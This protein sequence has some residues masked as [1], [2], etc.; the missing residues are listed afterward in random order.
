M[1]YLNYYL[2]K[3]YFQLKS[4]GVLSKGGRNFLGKICVKGRGRTQ[5]RIYN[6]IDFFRR[7]NLFGFILKLIYDCNRT[8]LIALVV[9]Q[10]G[11][12]SFI[13]AT[14][15]LTR[16]SLIFS[17]IID[18]KEPLIGWA[19]PINKINLFSI[20]NNIELKPYKGAQLARAAGVGSLLIGKVKNKIILK[21]NSKWQII[22]NENCI[23]TIGLCSNVNNKYK[24]IGSAGKARN[25][26]FRP[27][28]R[29]VAMNPCDH[30][31]GGG[32]GKH[33]K[34]VAPVSSYG[35]LTKGTPTKNKKFDKLNKR[36]FKKI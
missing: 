14:D 25:L 36:L 7:I 4:F 12:N 18:I 20:V 31:H 15:G 34:P 24:M 11:L 16:Q 8:S 29:G 13:I 2:K 10:N 33:S 19:L 3:V 6:F 21:L 28:V 27:K 5:K 26:G 32:N 30:P 9:Y 35:R 1:L 17:G 22:L 23:G